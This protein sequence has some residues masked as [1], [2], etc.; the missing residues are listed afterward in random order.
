MS[1]DLPSKKY[2]VNAGEMIRE[3]SKLP[4]IQIK[5]IGE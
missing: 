5:L 2:R 4:E 1:I 3:L